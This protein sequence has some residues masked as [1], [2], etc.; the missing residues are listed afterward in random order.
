MQRCLPIALT[1]LVCAAAFAP[2]ANEHHGKHA[3]LRA[4]PLEEV[5]RLKLEEAKDLR[6]RNSGPDSD[7]FLRMSYMAE[8]TKVRLS[9]AVRRGDGRVSIVADV[10]R[11]SPHGGRDG[12]GAPIASFDDAGRVAS[13]VASWPVDAVCVC[14]DPLLYDGRPE[15]VRSAARLLK[16]SE[17]PLLCKDIVVDPI[18]VA[19]AAELGADAVVLSAAILGNAL[20]DAL[21]ACT[22]CG[23]EG[24]CE[25]HT[26]NE[27]EF[28]LRAGAT[29][30]ICSNRDRATGELFPNQALGLAAL[31]PPNVVKIAAAGLADPSEIRMLAAEGYD[32]VMVG[33]RLLADPEAGRALARAVRG[34]EVDPVDRLAWG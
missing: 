27:L 31:A 13:E 1:L 3:P 30:L 24:A 32:G 12:G 6:A 16:G 8:R 19:L 23:V 34:L 11:R 7:V 29:L 4:A 15:D 9:S 33:R 18:Q 10:K 2:A 20:P 26:P 14:S 17:T 22:L 28:A 5:V 25:V 21:D